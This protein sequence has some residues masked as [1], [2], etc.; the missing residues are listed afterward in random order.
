MIL[1]FTGFGETLPLPRRTVYSVLP[2][3]IWLLPCTIF[4]TESNIVRI[5]FGRG[6]S[7]ASLEKQYGGRIHAL[8]E[9]TCS[10]IPAIQVAEQIKHHVNTHYPMLP[11]E[12]Y[13]ELAFTQ[14]SPT[15]DASVSEA[16]VEMMSD[17][18]YHKEKVI[19]IT[20]LLS[21]SQAQ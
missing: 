20:I 4:L 7:A 3:Y 18:Y 14:M 11:I 12:S 8:S 6:S 19:G 13:A 21:Q 17:G 10:D 5:D 15:R 16:L 1:L 9:I 2:R